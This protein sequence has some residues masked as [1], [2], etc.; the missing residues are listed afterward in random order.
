M[1]F[2]CALTCV[3]AASVV[4]ERQRNVEN[5]SGT[6]CLGC[7]TTMVSLLGRWFVVQLLGRRAPSIVEF[8][9]DAS[10]LHQ[11]VKQPA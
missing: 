2:W 10:M 3:G 5:L 11:P 8:H 9:R 6:A 4:D 7:T 1:A